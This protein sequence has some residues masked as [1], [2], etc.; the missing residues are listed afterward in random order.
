MTA[1]PYI[2]HR[3]AIL[4]HL[5]RSHQSYHVKVFDSRDIG[6]GV[7]VMFTVT[8]RDPKDRWLHEYQ[9]VAY[10]S[11]RDGLRAVWDMIVD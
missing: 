5:A 1:N 4:E 2:T 8:P 9:R 10:F 7:L 3:T 11:T 6:S